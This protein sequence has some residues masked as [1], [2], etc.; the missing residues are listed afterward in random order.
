MSG[1]D[2]G[3]AD[4][5]IASEVKDNTGEVRIE[6]RA[7]FATAEISR[8]H[9]AAFNAKPFSDDEPDW[10]EIVGRHSFGW[11][12]ARLD[13]KLVGFANVITDGFIHIWLQDV[14]VD[15]SQQ[16]SGLGRS[17]VDLAAQ[18]GRS[19]GCEWMHVDFAEDAAGFYLDGCGFKPSLAGLLYLQ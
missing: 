3:G 2:E 10:F 8:L 13:D 18:R 7:D 4:E 19:A 11:C 1:C 12:T 17:L 14:M 6:W 9:T 16:R 15:P 5:G